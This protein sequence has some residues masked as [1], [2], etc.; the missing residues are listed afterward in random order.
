M[1]EISMQQICVKC[2]PNETAEMTVEACS[3]SY[4]VHTPYS[5]KINIVKYM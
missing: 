1:C 2:K 3:A 4:G 5:V